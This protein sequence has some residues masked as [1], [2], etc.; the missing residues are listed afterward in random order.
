MNELYSDAARKKKGYD[1]EHCGAGPFK[2][3]RYITAHYKKC[4]QNPNRGD[5][6][7]TLSDL[8]RHKKEKHNVEIRKK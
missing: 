6:M 1:C 4:E 8:N 7:N 2:V 3:K 5:P